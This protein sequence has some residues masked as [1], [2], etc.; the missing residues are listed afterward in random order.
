MKKDNSR[1]DTGKLSSPFA[2]RIAHSLRQA[3]EFEKG[4][5]NGCRRSKVEIEPVP[6]FSPEEI[7]TIRS[8]RKLTQETFAQAMGVEK[9]T[10]EKWE[11]GKNPPSGPA[12]RLLKLFEE[13][14]T[15][16]SRL[17]KA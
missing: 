7:K 12:C 11:S 13:D 16:I 8:M 10:V 9:K 17:I 5:Q 15:F 3:V 4:V 14:D 6:S 2:E 1:N